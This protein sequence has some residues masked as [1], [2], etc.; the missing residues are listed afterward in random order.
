MYE[1][2][3]DGQ[4]FSRVEINLDDLYQGISGYDRFRQRF[5][6]FM[7]ADPLAQDIITLED[8]CLKYRTEHIHAKKSSGRKSILF[9]VGNPA[10]HS[11]VTGI[12][13]AYERGVN[14]RER[15]HRFW[16][17][18][19]ETGYVD[20]PYDFSDEEKKRILF[21]ADYD[22]EIIFNMEVFF[23]L[24]ST[25]SGNKNASHLIQK[26]SGVQQLLALLGSKALS[27]IAHKEA[28]RLKEIM[29]KYDVV[30]VC[31]RNAYYGVKSSESPEYAI[32]NLR[33]QF[34]QTETRN[35]TLLYCIPPTYLF[36]T[37]K[38]LNQLREIRLNII[39]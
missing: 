23:T 35:E 21:N 39:G 13:F 14:G 29:S 1:I 15:E 18:L 25:A 26:R 17:A 33:N 22:S 27:R 3:P 20:L 8:G 34:I 4:G 37:K 38:V 19:R 5:G 30:I 28:E 10:V 12:P 24:P 2:M 9:L 11:V 6:P 16:G 36:R 31:Q 32:A 7:Q